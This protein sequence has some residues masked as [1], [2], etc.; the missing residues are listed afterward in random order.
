M[1]NNLKCPIIVNIA[2]FVHIIVPTRLMILA[3]WSPTK[4]LLEYIDNI[5]KNGMGWACGAYG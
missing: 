5:K 2:I 1:S 3:E 4:F